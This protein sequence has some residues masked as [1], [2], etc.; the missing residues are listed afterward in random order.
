MR[1]RGLI[2]GVLALA[3]WGAVA[4]A[5]AGGTRLRGREPPLAA[6]R[7]LLHEDAYY[8]YGYY[9]DNDGDVYTD[10]EPRTAST[11]RPRSAPLATTNA[12]TRSGARRA[13]SSALPAVCAPPVIQHVDDGTRNIH[14][15]CGRD[16]RDQV[17]CGV[18]LSKP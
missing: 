11:T 6:S 2:G 8:Y 15:H 12:T 5:P 1:L 18:T 13:N 4:G 10:D 16:Y 7:R 3:L 17:L 14:G 9:Y